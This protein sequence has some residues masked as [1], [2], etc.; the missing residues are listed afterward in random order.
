M[1]FSDGT[2]KIGNCFK[3]SYSI[4]KFIFTFFFKKKNCS[5]SF[6]I[7]VDGS[8]K[9]IKVAS[10]HHIVG[11]NDKNEIFLWKDGDWNLVEGGLLKYVSI[12]PE[13]NI[14]GINENDEIWYLT[15]DN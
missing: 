11:V 12:S 15:Y 14:W 1:K 9:Q 13:G 3:S 2:E 7:S 8:L 10:I 5:F 4:F 6:R